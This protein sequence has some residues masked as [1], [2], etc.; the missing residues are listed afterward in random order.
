MGKC[1]FHK[2]PL[3]MK[4]PLTFLFNLNWSFNECVFCPIA[5]L[6]N[7]SFTYVYVW[8]SSF[9]AFDFF[10]KIERR[11]KTRNSFWRYVCINK[12]IFEFLR[13]FFLLSGTKVQYQYQYLSF[14]TVYEKSVI[15]IIKGEIQKEN[16]VCENDALASPNLQN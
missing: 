5:I 12:S 3:P 14:T 11:C 8:I 1:A 9:T 10:P 7:T 2:I 6:K 16:Q 4:P 15:W 13:A